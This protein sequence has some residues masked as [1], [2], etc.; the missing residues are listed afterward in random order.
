MLPGASESE[1]WKQDLKRRKPEAGIRGARRPSPHVGA[2]ASWI[3][4]GE[5][6]IWRARAR[7]VVTGFESPPFPSLILFFISSRPLPFSLLLLSS[8]VESSPGA[9]LSFSFPKRPSPR[10]GLEFRSARANR[11][12]AGR[13][14][15]GSENDSMR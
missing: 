13:E 12:P 10:P 8:R 15:S 14:R 9:C 2:P 11:D 1:I 5:G 7:A 3:C 4:A 6:R